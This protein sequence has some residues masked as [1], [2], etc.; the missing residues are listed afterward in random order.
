MNIN[1]YTNLTIGA[2]VHDY[3]LMLLG[4]SWDTDHGIDLG[5]ASRILVMLPTE[6]F[7]KTG[8]QNLPAGESISV[9]LNWD[10][11]TATTLSAKKN[12]ESVH[13]QY[14]HLGIG[15]FR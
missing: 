7:A 6:Y 14:I 3:K 2:N 5:T 11:C 15:L 13:A 12:V 9:T 8:T 4:Y 10:M 1:T